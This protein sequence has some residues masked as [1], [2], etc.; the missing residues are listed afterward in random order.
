LPA[1]FFV[2]GQTSAS[3][4]PADDSEL[5]DLER[6]REVTDADPERMRGLI[7]MY[8]AQ[9][10][11]ITTKLEH[12]LKTESSQDIYK[13]AHKLCGASSSCGMNALIAPLRQLEQCGKTGNL[14]DAARHFSEALCQLEATKRLLAAL[15]QR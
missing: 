8:L 6:L 4:F 10:A 12:A 5:L 11:E 2:G 1:D 3:A 9:A 7:D 13:L 14:S 15:S